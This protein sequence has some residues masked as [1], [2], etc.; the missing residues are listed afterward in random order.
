MLHQGILQQS[1]GTMQMQRHQNACLKIGK[2]QIS[3]RPRN[4]EICKVHTTSTGFYTTDVNFD[5]AKVAKAAYRDSGG[6]VPFCLS[7]LYDPVASSLDPEKS[8]TTDSKL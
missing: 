6:A 3:S 8:S 4:E 2:A 7:L 5:L 1:L